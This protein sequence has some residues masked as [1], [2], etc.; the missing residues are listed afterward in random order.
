MPA[1][2]DKARRQQLLRQLLA[3]HDLRSQREVR[4]L[5]AGHGVPTAQATVSRDLDELGA[6][7]VRGGDGALVYRLSPDP[8]PASAR[9]RLEDTIR[10]FVTSVAASGNLA[11]LR[12]PPACASPVASAIDLSDLEGVIATAAG[13]DTV[14][15]VAAET[16][17]GAALATRFRA[18]LARTA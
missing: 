2:M 5:L 1:T 15:V 3:E 13:D 18:M 16:T 8:G 12:T 9:S 11:V 17:S 7:K 10:Q 6:V 14:L 4:D